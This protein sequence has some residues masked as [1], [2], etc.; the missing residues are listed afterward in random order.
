M[1]ELKKDVRAYFISEA[2]L[3]DLLASDEKS[4][5]ENYIIEYPGWDVEKEEMVLKGFLSSFN[6]GIIE[7]ERNIGLSYF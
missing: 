6:D 2:D 7:F 5:A 3:Y 4:T 1:K